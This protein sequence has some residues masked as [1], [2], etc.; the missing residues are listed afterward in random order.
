MDRKKLAELRAEH[1]AMRGVPQKPSA[2][3]SLAERLGR[4]R[5]DRGKEPTWVSDFEIPPLSIPQHGK[6]SDLKKGT[7]HSI[8]NQLEDDLIAWEQEL[9]RRE[10]YA[11]E[12]AKA[13]KRERK[14]RGLE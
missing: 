5:E 8:L 14:K 3:V 12:Y 7:Q 13:L 1:E 9:D 2:L 6:S 11:E 10:R 4:K